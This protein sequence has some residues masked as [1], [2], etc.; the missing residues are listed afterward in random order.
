[1]SSLDDLAQ[2]V[3]DS[4]ACNVC[5]LVNAQDGSV[6]VLTQVWA[7]F[8]SSYFRCLDGIKQ[9]HYFRF[10]RTLLR[11]TAV[12]EEEERKLLWVAWRPSVVDKHPSVTLKGLSYERKKYLYQEIY[13][14]TAR[15]TSRTSS[16]LI[17]TIPYH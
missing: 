10:D 9:Y 11:K 2:V 6:L 15:M 5:Q 4:A 17:L 16:V 12:A 8:L 7:G 1:M 3:D 13:E 14:S